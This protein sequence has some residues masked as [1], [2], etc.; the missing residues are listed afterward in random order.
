MH[1]SLRHRN[2]KRHRNK[3]ILISMYSSVSMPSVNS[4][5]KILTSELRGGDKSREAAFNLWHDRSPQK[6]SYR[7]E[8]TGAYPAPTRPRCSRDGPRASFSLPEGWR[9]GGGGRPGGKAA[10][11]ETLPATPGCHTP[12]HS[13]RSSLSVPRLR[14][15][16][17]SS[18]VG[19]RR[20]GRSPL[21][22]PGSLLPRLPAG[23][24]C[25]P[26][27]AGQLTMAKPESSAEVRL[28]AFS[29]ARLR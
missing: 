13:L 18:P 20:S 5:Q 16:A 6:T 14:G 2:T 8:P 11:P 3:P 26:G 10:G 28:E 29:L 12:P 19:K 15:E 27:E 17:V 24:P 25:P 7:C 9:P 23:T 21:P 22:T 4:E 1:S